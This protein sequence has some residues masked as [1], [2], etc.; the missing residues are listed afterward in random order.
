MFHRG[1]QQYHRRYCILYTK[2]PA[3]FVN[4]VP[5]PQCICRD[6]HRRRQVQVSLFVPTF[7]FNH[8]SPSHRQALKTCTHNELNFWTCTFILQGPRTFEIKPKSNFVNL[9]QNMNT[10]SDLK[11]S[12]T[13]QDLQT[14]VDWIRH[15]C[16]LLCTSW[17]GSA[18]TPDEPQ[19]PWITLLH[20]MWYH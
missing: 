15:I 3:T 9:F 17:F 2:T 8:F 14:T 16:S 1:S 6:S 7:M 13:T 10:N 5:Q 18:S 11:P 19:C 20:S 4:E 12:Q